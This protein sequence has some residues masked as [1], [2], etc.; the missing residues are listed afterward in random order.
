[1]NHLPGRP[2]RGGRRNALY[3]R[4]ILCAAF[5]TEHIYPSTAEKMPLS[6]IHPARN[7]SSH[8]NPEVYRD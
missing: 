4:S 6:L 2:Q 5:S 3:C 7:S 1:M 8:E